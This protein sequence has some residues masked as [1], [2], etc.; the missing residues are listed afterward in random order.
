MYYNNNKI[1]D[2]LLLPEPFSRYL[3]V[4]PAAG[5]ADGYGGS[6]GYGYGNEDNNATIQ[7][8]ASISS[9]GRLM[10][11][12]KVVDARRQ[13]RCRRLSESATSYL[14]TALPEQ[15][16]QRQTIACYKL[17]LRIYN[18][19]HRPYGF[20]PFLYHI[21]VF[22]LV[23]LCLILTVF[24]T[25][26]NFENVSWMI[27]LEMEK[28]MV[29]WFGIEFLVRF[30]AS[31]C[32]I[33]YRGW[34]GKVRFV[35]N[36]LRIGDIILLIVSTC[37]L[38][39]DSAD[40]HLVFAA[41]ALR[42]FH[43]FFQVIQMIKSERRFRPASVLMSVIS[44]QREQ[45]IITTYIGFLVLCFMAF[46]IYIVETDVNQNFD[47]I[48]D[49]FWWAIITIFTIGYGDRV[50]VTWLGKLITCVFTIVGVSIFALPAG[51]IG[52]GLAMN[53]QEDQRAENRIKK[54]K[55]AAILIQRCWRYYAATPQ[56][57]SIA[58]WL[59]HRRHCNLIT[60]QERNAIR[61]VRM[62]QFLLAKQTF[63]SHLQE[64]DVRDVLEQY[65][66]G[67]SSI[68]YRIREIQSDLDVLVGK[69]QTNG[70]RMFESRA[71]LVDRIKRLETKHDELD[72]KLDRNFQLILAA[73]NRGNS[74]DGTN[75]SNSSSGSDDHF[76][77]SRPP[78]SSSTSTAANTG[79]VHTDVTELSS[80]SGRW[81]R[82][83]S[84]TSAATFS[85]Y[86]AGTRRSSVT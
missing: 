62:V 30:W 37:L 13:E 10:Q 2:R 33:Q 68:L 29:G 67:H 59:I 38:W 31:S 45:L 66:T 12:L 39:V 6:G 70:K 85:T 43:R 7:S 65:Q 41:F 80:S 51:I 48:A 73:I 32:K 49:S 81:S 64:R 34:R 86:S 15:Y 1:L 42:G 40:G 50:P 57:L 8:K 35:W 22:L 27:M 16:G 79:A 28:V 69:V 25:D 11:M 60:G 63:E 20:W 26:H 52:T 18:M 61:F 24:S 17:R 3:N 53:V 77:Q 75:G 76:R 36:P 4:G 21:V 71:G 72:E 23:F 78:S 74:G 9:V 56:S 58:T 19:L 14:G 54:R 83:S 47:S 5:S 82:K 44:A 46:L 55:P 84:T